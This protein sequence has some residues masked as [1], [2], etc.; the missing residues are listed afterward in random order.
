MIPSSSLA[1]PAASTADTAA[2]GPQPVRRWPRRLGLALQLLGAGL[3]LLAWW[4]PWGPPDWNPQAAGRA[5]LQS[6]QGRVINVGEALV[7][8]PQ[9]GA[10]RFYQV[11]VLPSDGTPLQHLR[12][13]PAVPPAAVLAL[14][15]QDVQALVQREPLNVV[16]ELT[17]PAGT[18]LRYEDSLRQLAQLAPLPLPPA[19]DRP[20]H[21]LPD[22]GVTLVSGLLALAGVLLW[23]W[24]R[25]RGAV[26]ST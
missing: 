19:H 26:P 12:L 24:G 18:V 9:G 13:H 7:P 14:G 11:T 8:L 6:L 4:A 5:Q 17:A 23:A 1:A 2:P 3:W 10:Q 21:A 15:G 20:R 16:Y 22:R 25:R